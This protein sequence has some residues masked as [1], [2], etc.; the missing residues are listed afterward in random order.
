MNGN[1]PGNDGRTAPDG[2]PAHGHA[3]GT[4]TTG[5]GTGVTGRPTGDRRGVHRGAWIGAGATLLGAL[6][7]V[8]GTYLLGVDGNR[9]ASAPP[10]APAPRPSSSGPSSSAPGT[11]PAP[12]TPA[13][14]STSAAS[15]TPTAKPG[16]TVRWEGTAVIVY[17]DDKDLDGTPPTQS[18]INE[19]NDFSVFRFTERVLRPEHGVRA[20][21]REDSGTLPSYADCAALVDAEGTKK[22]MPM[23]TGTVVCARTTDPA[24][25]PYAPQASARAPSKSSDVPR[26][27]PR[28]TPP[29]PAR[30]APPPRSGPCP[31]ARPAAAGHPATR[32]P[33]PPRPAVPRR[34]G[35]SP[36]GPAGQVPAV[37]LPYGVGLA[38]RAQ[39]LAAVR[40]HRLGSCLVW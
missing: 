19:E 21:V 32:A 13:A 9:P 5:A 16:G 28:G 14:S 11:E 31:R 39:P 15:P 23:K 10:P 4:G 20:A 35:A 17:A 25:P 34:A 29:P 37:P 36:R 26:R 7:T 24:P 30:P 6:I 40:L 18:E 2:G 33:R 1:Q 3:P 27:T 38:R 22:D 8:A 12:S